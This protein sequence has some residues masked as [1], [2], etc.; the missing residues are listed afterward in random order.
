MRADRQ[1]LKRRLMPEDIARVALFLISE[2]SGG[3]HRPVPRRR[4]RLGLRCRESNV[5]SPDEIRDIAAPAA[6]ATSEAL[7]RIGTATISGELNRLGIRDPHIRGP[8]PLVPGRTAAGPAL[9]LQFMPK[10]ED[11]FGGAEYDDPELQLHR[12]VLFP[13]AG[14]RH[15]GGRRARRHGQRHLRRDDADLLR[16][17]RRRRRGDRR[18]HPRLRPGASARPRH[19][20]ARR[21]AQLPRPDRPHPL[22]GQRADRLRRRA[23]DARRHHRRRRRRRGGGADRAGRR[24]SS[25]SAASTPNGR[26]S[27]ASACPRAATCANTTR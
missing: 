18:L 23:G 10:R 6:R 12:H 15:G 2:E 16:G 5:Q 3:D 7:A 26:N 1:A 13:A 20:G 11:L 21:D 22:R 8:V 27:P 9:T 25:P 4:R 19:L 14:R 24:R 17:P